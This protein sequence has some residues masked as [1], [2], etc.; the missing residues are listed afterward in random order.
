MESIQPA[1][2]P[3]AQSDAFSAPLSAAPLTDL[4]TRSFAER[5]RTLL[6]ALAGAVPDNLTP[7]RLQ[8]TAAYFADLRERRGQPHHELR[9]GELPAPRVHHPLHNFDDTMQAINWH[10]RQG[11]SASQALREGQLHE[12]PDGH[13]HLSPSGTASYTFSSRGGSIDSIS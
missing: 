10:E 8:R 3:T 7:E 5:M 6:P 12:P 9:P 11:G 2:E 1:L 4:R 13:D